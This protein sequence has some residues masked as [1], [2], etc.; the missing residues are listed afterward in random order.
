M[1]FARYLRH[2]FFRTLPGDC[3]CPTEKYFSNILVKSPL[4]EEKEWKQL[5]IKTRTNEEKKLKPFQNFFISL[6]SASY[7]TLK[8]HVFRVNTIPLGIYLL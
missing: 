3:H 1:N 8:E 5:V 2:L 4:N 7:D 6:F